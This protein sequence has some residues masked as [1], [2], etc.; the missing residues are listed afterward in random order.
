M[1]TIVLLMAFDLLGSPHLVDII[2]I[3]VHKL[4]R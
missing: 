4:L 1:S 2:E 3:A